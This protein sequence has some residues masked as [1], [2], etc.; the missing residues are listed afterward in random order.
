[1]R[2][3]NV[4][5]VRG[6]ILEGDPGSAGARLGARGREEYPM[7]WKVW[8]LAGGWIAMAAGLASGAQA[9]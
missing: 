5:E 6:V 1:M 8:V 9:Q 2:A 4:S 3:R 7:K